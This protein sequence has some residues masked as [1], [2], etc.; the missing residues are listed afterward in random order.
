MRGGGHGVYVL[1]IV[2]DLVW[3]RAIEH[4]PLWPVVSIEKNEGV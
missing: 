1:H 2:D 3:D 4:R